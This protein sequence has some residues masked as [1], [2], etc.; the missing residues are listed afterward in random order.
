[1]NANKIREYLNSKGLYAG[2]YQ[3]SEDMVEIEI[4]WGDW[5]HDHL[6]CKHLMEQIGFERLTVRVTEDN[7]S[8][9]YSGIHTYRK[10]A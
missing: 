10:A 1:M 9:C 3:L 6:Y 4:I 5:K 7:G 2:V 8:D